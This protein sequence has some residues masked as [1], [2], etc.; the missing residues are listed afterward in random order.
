MLRSHEQSI[1]A[2]DG[3]SD[4]TFCAWQVDAVVT[5]LEFSGVVDSGFEARVATALTRVPLVSS[6]AYDEDDDRGAGGE[7]PP[8][9]SMETVR[10]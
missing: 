8:F 2:S 9:P 10:V 4:T 1:S 6:G 7:A 5:P 3:R